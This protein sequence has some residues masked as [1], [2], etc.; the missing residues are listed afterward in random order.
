MF[1]LIEYSKTYL[2]TTG[3]LWN[4]YR[5]EPNSGAE[6]DIDYSIKNSKSFNYK[7]SI[8]GKLENNNVEKDNV[9]I[10]VSLKYA[11]N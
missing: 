7:S 4:Y 6:G 1:N 9:E 5:D 3:R 10:V 2:K 8:T 11:I